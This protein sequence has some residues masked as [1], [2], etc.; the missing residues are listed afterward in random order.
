MHI[1][2]I[3]QSLRFWWIFMLSG[4]FLIILGIYVFAKPEVSYGLISFYFALTFLLNGLLEIFFSIT[5]HK[6]IAGWVLYL[7]GGILDLIISSIFVANPILAAASLPL[8]VGVWLFFRSLLMIS[9]SYKLMQWGIPNWEWLLLFG[10]LG[11]VLAWINIYNPLFAFRIIVTW[12][13][14]ALL[15]AGIFYIY[16]S[17]CLKNVNKSIHIHSR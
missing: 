11:F 10:L 9:R 6:A 16:F 13:G 4:A 12:T 1:S 17:V 2:E 5:N 15:S 8:L 14:L 3:K 7:T